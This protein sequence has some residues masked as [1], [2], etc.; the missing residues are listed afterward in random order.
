MADM[1]PTMSIMILSMHG[2]ELESKGR[3]CQTRSKTKTKEKISK[4]MLP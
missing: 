1:N 3:N 4:Y 2:L